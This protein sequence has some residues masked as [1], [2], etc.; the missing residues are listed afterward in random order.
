ML[1]IHIIFSYCLLLFCLLGNC[2]KHWCEHG[3]QKF[4]SMNVMGYFKQKL[5]LFHN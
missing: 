2:A 1:M 4:L 5:I 3:G